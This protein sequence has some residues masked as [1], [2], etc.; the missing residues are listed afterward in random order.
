[1]IVT[2]SLTLP[3]GVEIKGA[4][5]PG[6]EEVLSPKALQLVAELH[7]KFNARRLELLEERKHSQ[8]RLDEGVLP[9]FLPET[10]AIREGNW[11]VAPLPDDL[12]D[13]RVEI[14]GPVDRKMVINALNS[15]AK[16][17]MADFEDSNSPT[18]FNSI[19][20]Q[21]NMRDAANRTI[22]F[23]DENK[24]KFYKLNQEI[25]TLMV[26]PRGWHLTE[27]NILI[28][29]EEASG[30]L[31]DFGLFMCNSAHTLIARG[32]GPYFYLPKLESY[33]EA[34]L[35]NEIFI[36]TQSK[37]NLPLGSIKATVLIETFAGFLSVE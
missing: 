13:R 34:R 22:T 24:G 37:I 1:M 36:F 18:W 5:Y 28:D 23:S 6:F 17:F 9:D 15:G 2:K 4:I 21:I 14:T 3:K 19:Q 12:Q 25:A 20:G 16:V 10:K 30:A 33:L 35:W 32:S 31:V 27:K 8:K 7:R 11:T 26:R 29:G